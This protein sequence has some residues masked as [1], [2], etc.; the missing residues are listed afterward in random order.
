MHGVECNDP[1]TIRSRVR[2]PRGAPGGCGSPGI[3]QEES[4]RQVWRGIRLELRKRLTAFCTRSARSFWGNSD[5]T[6]CQGDEHAHI[7]LINSVAHLTNNK[8]VFLCIL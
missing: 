5:N 2:A 4:S 6:S 8:D 3:A 1:S 7:E